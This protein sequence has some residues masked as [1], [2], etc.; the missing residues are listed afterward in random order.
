MNIKTSLL[1]APESTLLRTLPPSGDRDS[2]SE[3]P[4]SR[5]IFNLEK[6]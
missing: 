1:L 6:F 2:E 5:R 3:I 4:S